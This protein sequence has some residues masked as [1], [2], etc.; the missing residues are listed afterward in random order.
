MANEINGTD[1]CF[2]GQ[3]LGPVTQLDPV[4]W[5]IANTISGI[6]RGVTQPHSDRSGDRIVPQL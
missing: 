4:G 2:R 1:T 6:A 5:A 3:F